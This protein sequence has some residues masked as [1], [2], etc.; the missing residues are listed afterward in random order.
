MI[1]LIIVVK[2]Y[3]I[4]VK[5]QLITDFCYLLFTNFDTFSVELLA[6]EYEI[7]YMQCLI[8]KRL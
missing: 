2:K 3:L 8:K 5:F 7:D 4:F 1:N 6:F